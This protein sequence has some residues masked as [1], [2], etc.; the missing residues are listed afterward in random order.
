MKEHPIEA[1]P[2]DTTGSLSVIAVNQNHNHN[3]NQKKVLEKM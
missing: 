1:L 3:H 2:Q